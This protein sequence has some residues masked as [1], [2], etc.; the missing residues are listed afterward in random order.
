MKFD[1]LTVML[2]KNRGYWDVMLWLLV[3]SYW[4]FRGA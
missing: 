4:Y 1:V 2:R 3:N